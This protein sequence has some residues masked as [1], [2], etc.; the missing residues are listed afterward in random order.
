M[1]TN[2]GDAL[3]KGGFSP[4]TIGLAAESPFY[5]YGNKAKYS[6]SFDGEIIS[7]TGSITNK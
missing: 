5:E 3:N 6:N 1:P 7:E 4:L 2:N